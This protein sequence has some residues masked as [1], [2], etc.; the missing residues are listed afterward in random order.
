MRVQEG[1]RR[2]S[3]AHWG[4]PFV[5]AAAAA[6]MDGLTWLRA[7]MSGALPA[8][9][10]AEVLKFALE[11][12]EPGVVAFGFDAAEL[13]YNPLGTVHGGMLATVCDSA[14]ACAVRS[15]LPAG[16][17]ASTVE[18]HLNIVRPVTAAT[19]H[20]SCEAQVVYRGSRMATAEAKLRDTT[21]KL[22][23]H[24]TTTCLIVDI[25]P[26]KTGSTGP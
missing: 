4:D 17:V 23:A 21:G 15:E 2:E 3:T 7:I 9:P 14:L 13:H 16:Q 20:L 8:P 12:V 5:T 25:G 1:P 26:G 18:L 19:G 6:H 11:S 10:I 22:Y 24:A